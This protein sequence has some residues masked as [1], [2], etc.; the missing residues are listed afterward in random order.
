[1]KRAALKFELTELA[2]VAAGAIPGALLRWHLEG[3]MQG[4]VGAQTSVVLRGMLHADF[5]A[6]L[7]GCFCLGLL[8]GDSRPPRPA[9]PR[10]YLLAGVGFCGSL[11][12]FSTWMLITCQALL[13]GQLRLAGSV[14]GVSLLGGLVALAAGFFMRRRRR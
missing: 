2:L 11:T 1:M 9:R 12:T 3:L 10:L 7:L 6:N 13:Q 14:L 4:L 8:I 5:A